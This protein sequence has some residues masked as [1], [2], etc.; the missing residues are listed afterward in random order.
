MG[1]LDLGATALRILEEAE[2]ITLEFEYNIYNYRYVKVTDFS[3]RV[4][5]AQLG[6]GGRGPK[7]G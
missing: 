2:C 6:G 5:E 1:E 4:K 7:T 3:V